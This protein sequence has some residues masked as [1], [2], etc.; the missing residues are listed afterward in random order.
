MRFRKSGINVGKNIELLHRSLITDKIV[1]IQHLLNMWKGRA[2]TIKGKITLLR[3][4]IIPMLL[5]VASVVFVSDDTIEQID[6]MIYDLIW[7]NGKHHVK[8]NVLI[9]DIE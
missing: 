4:K 6:K 3:S 7:P 1:K 9:Q 8:K 2:L 5:Y